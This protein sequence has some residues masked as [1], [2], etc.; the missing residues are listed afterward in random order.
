MKKLNVHEM[1][2]INGG[3]KSNDNWVC[4]FG[5]RGHVKGE[6]AAWHYFLHLIGIYK[7]P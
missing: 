2:K 4:P 3:G 7:A 1:R 6:S 5:C